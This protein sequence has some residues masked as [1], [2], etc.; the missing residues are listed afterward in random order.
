VPGRFGGP[1][2]YLE[3]LA[4]VILP[5]VS[6][7]CDSRFGLAASQL[8]KETVPSLTT[9]YPRL[10]ESAREEPLAIAGRSLP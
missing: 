4:A 9:A 10:R 6:G 3:G 1:D 7:N 2:R 5:A 8:E